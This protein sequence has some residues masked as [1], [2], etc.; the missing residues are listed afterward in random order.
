MPAA[1]GAY[2]IS[3]KWTVD[4]AALAADASRNIQ[5]ALYLLDDEIAEG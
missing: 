3:L 1:Y 5:R 2:Q 4:S